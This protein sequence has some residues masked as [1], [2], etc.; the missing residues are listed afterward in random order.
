MKRR[1]DYCCND[2]RRR[3]IIE[4]TSESEILGHRFELRKVCVCQLCFSY[5]LNENFKG[6]CENHKQGQLVSRSSFKPGALN[7]RTCLCAV[8]L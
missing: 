3:F 5:I 6:D 1:E 7:A 8:K 2:K 4:Q